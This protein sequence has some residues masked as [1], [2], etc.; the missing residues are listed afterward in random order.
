MI[1]ELRK[2]PSANSNGFVDQLWQW[3]SISW[4]LLGSF[5]QTNWFEHFPSLLYLCYFIRLI[6]SLRYNYQCI[7]LFFHIYNF[8]PSKV[9]YLTFSSILILRLWEE[10]DSISLYFSH[11]SIIQQHGFYLLSLRLSLFFQFLLLQKLLP[12][13][14][15]SS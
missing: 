15:S 4:W 3:P 14:L 9:H 2:A 13:L 12:F 1:L 7:V 10:L 5:W 11:W 6:L 8:M